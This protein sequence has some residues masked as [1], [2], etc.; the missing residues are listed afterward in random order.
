[1]TRLRQGGAAGPFIEGLNRVK[2]AP[3]LVLGVWV[4]TLL[5]AMP[6]AMLAR[7]SCRRFSA[8]PP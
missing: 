8:S 1:M 5:L 2:R 6:L 7:A 4:S 3:W